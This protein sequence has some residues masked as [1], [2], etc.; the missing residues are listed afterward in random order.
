MKPANFNSHKQ[1]IDELSLDPAS[2]TG[3]RLCFFLIGLELIILAVFWHRLPPQ[4]PLF[5]S[6][7]YGE[8]RLV[9]N[10][11]LWLVPV[12]TFLI[13]LVS[14]R[15]AVKTKPEDHIWAQMLAWLGTI[16]A[17]MGLATL[18]KIIGIMV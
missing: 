11:W 4:V 13:Q 15:L 10:W 8:A 2:K 5:Y 17:A 3:L 9:S 1:E 7:A 6:R 14:I 18:G 16:L 12:T